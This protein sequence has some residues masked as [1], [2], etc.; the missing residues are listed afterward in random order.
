MC[1]CKIYISH[2]DNSSGCSTDVWLSHFPSF[3]YL[4]KSKLARTEKHNIASHNTQSYERTRWLKRKSQSRSSNE[5]GARWRWCMR[6][7]SNALR[8]TAPQLLYLHFSK[9]DF[10]LELLSFCNGSFP[11]NRNR[12]GCK[13]LRYISSEALLRCILVFGAFHSWPHWSWWFNIVGC[14]G[15]TQVKRTCARLCQ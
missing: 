2:D 13:N 3:P 7:V 15:E 12:V 10:L 14:V 6:D 1:L 11:S 9:L 4:F 8:A 5:S